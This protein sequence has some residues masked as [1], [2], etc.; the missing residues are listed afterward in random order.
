MLLKDVSSLDSKIEDVDVRVIDFG[1]YINM[2]KYKNPKDSLTWT[3]TLGY[4]SPELYAIQH[5]RPSTDTI[6]KLTTTLI[7]MEM[8]RKMLYTDGKVD[9]NKVEEFHQACEVYALSVT[10]FE[11][12]FGELPTMSQK[13]LSYTADEA[14]GFFGLTETRDTNYTNEDKQTLFQ[15]AEAEG[16]PDDFMKLIWRGFNP[17]PTERPSMN[18]FA[19]FG[20]K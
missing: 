11:V 2:V 13:I 6:G 9:E 18:D 10:A 5:Y 19:T 4:A 7:G 1:K 20:L 16:I 3:G 12:L 15:K 14:L 17:D 8:A